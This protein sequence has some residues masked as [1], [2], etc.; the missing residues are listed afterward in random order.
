MGRAGAVQTVHEL[1]RLIE[2]V[3]DGL[4]AATNEANS[5][6]VPPLF[7]LTDVRCELRLRDIA[8]VRN[9]VGQLL[10]P[11]GCRDTV[12]TPEQ[13]SVETRINHLLDAKL[14]Y[15][16][17]ANEPC[18]NDHPLPLWCHAPSRP[19]SQSF[20][21]LSPVGPFVVALGTDEPTCRLNAIQLV[22]HG[23]LTRWR[24]RYRGLL[25]VLQKMDPLRAAVGTNRGSERD[26]S[27]FDRNI[28][29]CVLMK[30]DLVFAR[31]IGDKVKAYPLLCPMQ[32]MTSF[33]EPMLAATRKYTRRQT[34]NSAPAVAQRRERSLEKIENSYLKTAKKRIARQQ[35]LQVFID[36][37]TKAG[38]TFHHLREQR[39]LSTFGEFFPTLL[40]PDAQFDGVPHLASIILEHCKEQGFVDR[41]GCIILP[42][43]AAYEERK[44]EQREARLAAR[45]RTGRTMRPRRCS[46][47]ARQ[48]P[49]LA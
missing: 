30:A 7:D 25:T 32:L 48:S 40:R 12:R 31:L 28:R 22:L 23:F 10:Q 45:R 9:F 37:Y 20:S 42:E 47:P 2:E 38:T 17:L 41:D 26:L 34:D 29:R 24:V 15:R 27:I 13:Q 21:K 18:S 8:Q 35:V 44:V 3:G 33:G 39:L 16:D 4:C 5:G 46:I 11:A 1:Q 19:V 14:T 49:R 43:R 36:F 6:V